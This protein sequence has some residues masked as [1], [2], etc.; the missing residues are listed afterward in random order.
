MINMIQYRF[1]SWID[2]Y[3]AGFKNVG[4]DW[5]ALNKLDNPRKT[6]ILRDIPLNSESGQ[7]QL[8]K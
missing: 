8:V 5:Q 4:E 3:D 1:A 7:I 6:T 2:M